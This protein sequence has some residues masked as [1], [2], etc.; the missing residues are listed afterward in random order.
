M[1]SGREDRNTHFR[2]NISFF[3]EIL[4]RDNVE[5]CDRAVLATGDY[6]MQRR[7]GVI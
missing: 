3:K 1:Q 5:E 2:F 7:K 4:L 6:I